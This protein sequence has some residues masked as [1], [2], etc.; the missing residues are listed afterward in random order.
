MASGISLSE[1]VLLGSGGKIGW[2]EHALETAR[3]LSEINPDYIRFRTLA[4]NNRMPLYDEIA[5]GNFIRANDEDIIREERVIIEN[6]NCTSNLVSDHITNLL[7]ELEGKLPDDK[8]KFLATIDRFL[9]LSPKEKLIFELGRRMGFFGCLNDL[10][11]PD[12][13]RIVERYAE[14]LVNSPPEEVERVIG[15]LT[16]GFI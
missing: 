14:R 8:E 5:R 7:Q 3:V 12:R 10:S 4:V 6:L 1:Y 13:R 9:G 15:E 11:D 2:K 16:E